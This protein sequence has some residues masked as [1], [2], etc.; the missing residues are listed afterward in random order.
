[1]NV[2]LPPLPY[3]KDALEP[4]V[5]GLTME[6]HYEKHHRGY[7]EK[8]RQLLAGKPEEN[9]TLD[10]LVRTSDG[11]VFDNAAQVWNHTFF[12]YSLRP[13]GRP[14]NGALLAAIER[15]F[16][17]L[18]ELQKQLAEAAT[19][20]FGSGWAWLVLDPRERLRVVS[21]RDADNPLRGGARPHGARPARRLLLGSGERRFVMLSW[22][23][24]FLVIALIAALFGFTGI[25]G[26][27]SQIAQVLFFVFLV[28]MIVAGVS[29]AVRGRPPV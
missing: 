9:A 20:H 12:W 28:L 22:A 16:G 4:Y 15:G 26:A 27:A 14:P 13:G 21:T 18:V 2:T 6:V 24:T 23:L 3:A 17:D 19:S 5:S 11:D 7:L 29:A 25:A 10:H 1:M 8:L